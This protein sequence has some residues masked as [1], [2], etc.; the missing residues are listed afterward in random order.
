MS[1]EVKVILILSSI[2][3]LVAFAFYVL[4]LINYFRKKFH[5]K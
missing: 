2:I 4:E 3:I 5:K 1:Y